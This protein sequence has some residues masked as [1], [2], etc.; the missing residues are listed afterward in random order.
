MPFRERVKYF[1]LIAREYSRTTSAGARI[2][3][4]E[5]YETNVTAI[6]RRVCRENDVLLDLVCARAYVCFFF[7]LSS[8]VPPRAPA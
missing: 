2:T 4:R 7:F 1:A 3:D 5:T 6:N 8:P